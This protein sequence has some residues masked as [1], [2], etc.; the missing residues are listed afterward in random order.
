MK[1]VNNYYYGTLHFS[2]T[3][4][5]LF[6]PSLINPYL[7]PMILNMFLPLTYLVSEKYS[8]YIIGRGNM[9]VGARKMKSAIIVFAIFGIL[10]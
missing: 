8:K 5:Q 10:I 7:H 2:P 4:N 3:T 9:K 1:F 6:N